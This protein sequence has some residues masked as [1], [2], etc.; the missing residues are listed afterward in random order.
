MRLFMSLLCLLLSLFFFIGVFG[1][2]GIYYC[3]ILAI[4][5]FI[6][7]CKLNNPDEFVIAWSLV[8]FFFLS[9]I[10]ITFGLWAGFITLGASVAS[11]F[12]KSY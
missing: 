7:T 6:K 8:R 10:S 12:G 3:L 9:G 5:D 11:L 1:Y 2:F 4:V